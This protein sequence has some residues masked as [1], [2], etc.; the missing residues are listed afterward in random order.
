MMIDSEFWRGRRIFITGHTGFKGGW[1]ATWLTQ[2]GAEVF[3]FSLQPNTEPSLFKVCELEKHLAGHT[4]GDIR[5]GVEFSQALVNSAAEIVFHFAAQPLVRYSYNH[6]VETYSTN[7]IGTVNLLEA[8][9]Q[10]AT[11]QAVVNVTTDKCYENQE[12]VWGYRESEPLGGMDPYSSSKACAELVSAAYRDSFLQQQGVALATVRAGN[13][14]GGGDWADDRL[15]PDF[16]RALDR[17]EKVIIRS[18]GAVRPWQHVLEPLSGY[19][20]LAQRLFS[21][22]ESFS[23]AWNFGPSDEDSQT[24]E[25]IIKVLGEFCPTAQWSIEPDSRIHEAQQL[26]LDSSKARS[27]LAWMPRWDIERAL[28]ETVQWHHAWRQG[29]DMYQYASAQISRY[30]Q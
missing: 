1:L 17:N 19:M 24:V 12:W 29:K 21:E 3:G 15:I 6:P 16:L 7:V 25:W 18:P 14:I 23:E 2:M 30:L 4:I 10:S 11:V 28:D 26:R 5:N 8:V 13:V 22:G 20:Q 9:R 27:R